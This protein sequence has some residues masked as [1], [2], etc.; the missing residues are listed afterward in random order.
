MGDPILLIFIAAGILAL[1][2]A[3]TLYRVLP[4]WLAGETIKPGTEAPEAGH[5]R[6]G[7]EDGEVSA[8]VAG[9]DAPGEDPD[10]PDPSE[11]S[12]DEGPLATVTPATP[13]H[14]P[15]EMSAFGWMMAVGIAL[16]LLPLWPFIAIVWIL[17]KVGR[18]G[19]RRG[20]RHPPE[21]PPI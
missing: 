3:V 7:G 10:E 4:C 6:P 9:E 5:S 11:E 13:L 17:G 1:W 19:K 16:V 8:E 18:S 14:S 12:A 15:W 20:E 2:L 21:D